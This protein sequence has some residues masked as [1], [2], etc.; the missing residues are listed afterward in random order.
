MLRVPFAVPKGSRDAARNCQSNT[1]SAQLT[2]RAVRTLGRKTPEMFCSR[3]K[4]LVQLATLT[5]C[6]GTK[7]CETLLSSAL[8]ALQLALGWRLSRE[9]PRMFACRETHLEQLKLLPFPQQA[10]A[11]SSRHGY[12][13]VDVLH[14][15]E[16]N[17]QTPADQLSAPS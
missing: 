6:R 11:L 8:E 13:I 16:R 5:A 14:K 12:K 1:A 17:I 10:L 7:R 9:L 4:L 2:I 15:V 3:R